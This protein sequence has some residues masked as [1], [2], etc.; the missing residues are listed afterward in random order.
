MRQKISEKFKMR[1]YPYVNQLVLTGGSGLRG[2]QRQ[3]SKRIVG[4]LGQA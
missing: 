3:I 4:L 2:A 1:R